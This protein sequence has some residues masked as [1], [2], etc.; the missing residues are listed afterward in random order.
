MRDSNKRTK[1]IRRR[2]LREWEAHSRILT[3]LELPRISNSLWYLLW[4]NHLLNKHGVRQKPVNKVWYFS[5]ERQSNGRVQVDKWDRDNVVCITWGNVAH[6]T[7]ESY[8]LGKGKLFERNQSRKV[9]RNESSRVVNHC[10][11]N[12]QRR[13]RGRKSEKGAKIRSQ[14][15]VWEKMRTC[16]CIVYTW[17]VP[18]LSGLSRARFE[19]APPLCWR[20]R[21]I[22]GVGAEIFL[23]FI[24]DTAADFRL[25]NEA[26]QW[27]TRPPIVDRTYA[28]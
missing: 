15:R 13:Q 18:R 1:G 28:E 16:E 3:E 27:E 8:I 7:A 2:C 9:D 19:Y 25:A 11:V 10:L 20:L 5:S 24:S 23:R 4:T 26:G 6:N 22:T 14:P 17:M 21:L 12:E